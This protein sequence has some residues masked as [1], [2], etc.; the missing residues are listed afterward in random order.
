MKKL[1][2]YLKHAAEYR[3]M[4]RTSLPSHRIQLERMA[5]TW[6]QLAETRKQQMEKHG[7]TE[8]DGATEAK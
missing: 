8:D 3:D 4:A 1:D 5:Q 7:K 2:E 6:E